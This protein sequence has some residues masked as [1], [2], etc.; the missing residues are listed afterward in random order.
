MS[1]KLQ[2]SNGYIFHGQLHQRPERKGR[3]APPMFGRVGKP[4]AL[5][6]PAITHSMRRASTGK[7]SAYHHGIAQRDEPLE[8]NKTYEKGAL[9]I[10]P[11]MVTEPVSDDRMRGTHDP[12]RAR[13]VLDEAGRLGAPVGGYRK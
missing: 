13:D 3:S 7:L 5:T 2:L 12:Q 6:V 8:G 9:P 1:N 11:G 10:H 4:K